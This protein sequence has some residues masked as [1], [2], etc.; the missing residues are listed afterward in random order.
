[1]SFHLQPKPGVTCE[2]HAAPIAHSGQ[3][4]LA[5]VARLA[6]L[7]QICA[8]ELSSIAQALE[9]CVDELP[10]YSSSRQNMC[11]SCTSRRPPV[12]YLEELARATV[13]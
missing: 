3:N 4:E 11:S 2:A 13:S 10:S 6:H 12:S 1:M 8:G 7:G 5:H 9:T